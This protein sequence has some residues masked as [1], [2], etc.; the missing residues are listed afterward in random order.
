MSEL[1]LAVS[2]G[3]LTGA[4]WQKTRAASGPENSRI[5]G[6]DRP[7]PH[8]EVSE[9]SREAVRSQGEW[10]R[11]SPGARTLGNFLEGPAGPDRP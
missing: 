7:V 9:G 8:L 1:D 3:L 10:Q 5:L 4:L 2:T 11:Q 6:C